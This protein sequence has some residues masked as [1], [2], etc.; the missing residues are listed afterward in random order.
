M[1][2]KKIDDGLVLGKR[3]FEIASAVSLIVSLCALVVKNS[4]LVAGAFAVFR[5]ALLARFLISRLFMPYYASTN[6]FRR[7]KPLKSVYYFGKGVD[8]GE[9][10]IV[11]QCRIFFIL[12]HFLFAY[13]I[14]HDSPLID[15]EPLVTGVFLI[16]VWVALFIHLFRVVNFDVF[17]TSFIAFILGWIWAALFLL[18]VVC[19]DI[20]I[21]GKGIAISAVYLTMVYVCLCAIV[22]RAVAFVT[23]RVNRKVEWVVDCKPDGKPRRFVIETKK[24]TFRL[25]KDFQ[26]LVITESGYYLLMRSKFEMNII[27][28]KEVVKVVTGK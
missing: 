26:Y 9:L 25:G 13:V 15:L 18:A 16:V 7:D 14:L 19:Y 10:L 20:L 21:V 4:F 24:E 27:P 23:D 3:I 11:F 1:L 22:Y 2:V 5:Y 17:M 28:E 12:S 6:F 8:V